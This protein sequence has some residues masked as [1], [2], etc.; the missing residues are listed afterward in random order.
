MMFN[1]NDKVR[2]K[3][4]D[5]GRA[6]H[7]LDHACFVKDWKHGDPPEYHA[8]EEDADGWSTWA[9]WSLMNQF[10]AHLTLGG[11]LPF[12]TWI[13][14]VE[15]ADEATA[16]IGPNWSIRSKAAVAPAADRVEEKVE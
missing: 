12:E 14:I 6:I 8:P 7:R 15:P 11:Q 16:Y 2:V 4:T 1:I 3:L 5:L 13:D 10:G 9:M